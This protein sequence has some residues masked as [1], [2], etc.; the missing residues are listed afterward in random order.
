MV[1]EEYERER[2]VDFIRPEFCY[3]MVVARVDE[4]YAPGRV[5]RYDA[6]YGA[7]PFLVAVAVCAV[8][9]C[10]VKMREAWFRAKG[11]SLYTPEK[12]III[13]DLSMSFPDFLFH[14]H[15]K[16]LSVMRLKLSAGRL[17]V[18]CRVCRMPFYG[19]SGVYLPSL[20]RVSAS[21]LPS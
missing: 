9:V 3:V 10:A 5:G 16:S 14:C 11:S 17:C 13:T 20:D 21:R 7:L 18:P 15:P 4:V 2:R 19:I 6:A 12:F 8:Q 1:V